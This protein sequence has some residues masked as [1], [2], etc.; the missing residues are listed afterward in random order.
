MRSGANKAKFAPAKASVG[1]ESGKGA[2][3]SHALWFWWVGS[4][5]FL[6]PA[7]QALAPPSP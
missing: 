4:G 5:F 7:G 2:P 3:G 1:D 6:V